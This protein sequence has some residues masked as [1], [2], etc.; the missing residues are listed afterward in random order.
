MGNTKRKM[1]VTS[2][3]LPE[4][5]DEQLSE[6]AAKRHVSRSA[7]VREALEHYA[8]LAATSVVDAAGDLVGA[9]EGPHDL[10]TNPK[11]MKGYGH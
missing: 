4:E 7:I 2:V 8:R 9:A 5:L 3:K 11:H 1:R 6:L 10:A